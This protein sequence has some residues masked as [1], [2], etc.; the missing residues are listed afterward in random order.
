MNILHLTIREIRHRKLSFSMGLV[1]I[2]IAVCALMGS[3]ILLKAHDQ[4]TVTILREKE[5]VLMQKTKVLG[6]DVRKAMLKLGFNLV[7]NLPF[8]R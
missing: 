8:L 7:I 3:L 1:S 4:R 2:A 6:D 5:A